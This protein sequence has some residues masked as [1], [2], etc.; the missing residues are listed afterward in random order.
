MLQLDDLPPVLRKLLAT[1]IEPENWGLNLKE[2][3]EKAGVKYDTVRAMIARVGSLDF[4][5][6]KARLVDKALVKYHDDILKALANKAR[7]GHARAIELYLKATQRL[8]EKI[9]VSGSLDINLH[10]CLV[11]A[12]KRAEKLK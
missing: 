9:E 4:Y 8:A 11:E 3:C 1:W 10:Q 7:K 2:A 12:K 5:E 6:L